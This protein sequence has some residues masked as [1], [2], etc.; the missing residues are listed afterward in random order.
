MAKR[1]N[2]L[3]KYLKKDPKFEEDLAE[4]ILDSWNSTWDDHKEIKIK[5]NELFILPITQ[6]PLFPGTLTQNI[7]IDAGPYEE[8]LKEL[9][10]SKN[11]N[12]GL[13]L[14]RDEVSP[15]EA[16]FNDLYQVGVQAEILRV[17]STDQNTTQI[18]FSIEKRIKI[19]HY[20]D[21]NQLPLR[22]QVSYYKDEC[23]ITDEIKALSLCILTVIKQLI[24]LNPIYKEELQTLS[25]HFEF[26]Q[27]G[28]LAD[29]AAAFTCS[30]KKEL[31]NI[32]ETFD[33]KDRLIQ[34][35]IL[36]KN[37][38]DLTS[39]KFD[40]NAKVD[41]SIAK[42]QKEYFL[43]EQLKTIKKE[44]GI[45]KDDKS[46]DRDKFLGRIQDLKVPNS[47]AKIIKDEMEKLDVLEPHSGEYS[48]VRNYL[49]WLTSIP[50]NLHSPD[51]QNLLQAETILEEDHFGLEDI[52]ERILEHVAVGTLTSGIKSVI[53][54]LVGPP[55]VGKTSIGKSIA[56]A[57]GRTFYRFSVGGMRDEGEIKGHRR[58]YLGAMPG[59]IIQ[60]IKNCK[61]MNPVIMIDE[62]DK[63][64]TGYHGD[65]ASAL[66][67]VL[68]PEQN[69]DF[70]D[71]Y[72]DV[73]TDLSGILFITTANTLDTIP[74]ALR[75]RMEILRL[76]GYIAQEKLEI[77]SKY[78]IP[79][80][81]KEMG[82]KESQINFTKESILGIINDYARESGVRTLE[83][84][85]KK[86]LRKVAFKIAKN[87]QGA[88]KKGSKNQ[89]TEKNLTDYLGKP[90]FIGDRFYKDTPIGV[91]TGLAW[92]SMGGATL[93]VESIRVKAEQNSMELTGQVGDVM[94]E[95]AKIAWS[96]LHS[97]APRYAPTFTFFEKT[98]VHIHIPEGATPKDGPSAGITLVTSLL[99]LLMNIPVMENLGMTGELTLTGRVLP[100][101]GIKEKLV[102][103]KRSGLKTL[104]LP[105]DN[106]RDVDKLS[107]NVVEGLTL[108]F[109]E[110]YDEVFPIAFGK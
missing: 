32:L 82:L 14:T 103:A 91:C 68:D 80:H 78:L 1:K 69:S 67:E 96:Y 44:L 73:R 39:L 6:R 50:W 4:A 40:F 34:S 11:R 25:S 57:L 84:E 72:L 107:N 85:I 64:S 16:T 62:I 41:A 105:K 31:Q 63:M 22:A 49:D 23:E 101:G 104:I 60:A 66:L 33:V 70:L 10:R 24:P 30:N 51:N 98:Q 109:I 71:H 90:K 43:R 12:I 17:M 47:V 19:E 65:P 15:N 29:L 108:H 79:R 28:K 106:K 61:K 38:L 18:I 58:T 8:A 20:D 9:I 13:V 54:C 95:S 2:D 76:S 97:A 83:H 27:P 88:S 21:P 7:V 42:T 35:L 92:T 3:D 5:T 48:I 74:D 110:H 45:D 26:N 94:K 56:R 86:I 102:A 52:K 59:K 37:E 81:Q 55:G 99:S 36:L 53:L 46:L 87:Q 100:V 93:Y 77:A 89:I 75:D